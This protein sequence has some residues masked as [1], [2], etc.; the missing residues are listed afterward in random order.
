MNAARF[1]GGGLVGLVAV[2]VVAC[3]GSSGGGAQPPGKAPG[4]CAKPRGAYVV[5]TD[6][7]D[8]TC[9][10][11]PRHREEIM[12]LTEGGMGMQPGCTA[13][14]SH[15]TPSQNGCVY[16]LTQRCTHAGGLRS[17]ATASVQIPQVPTELRGT[18]VYQFE[19]GRE[20][21]LARYAVRYVKNGP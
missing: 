11:L 10:A 16:E 1:V 4:Q 17:L 19:E 7:I 14:D 12:V 6:M 5:T 18:V 20:R 8:G 13:V 15:W 9:N 3:G 2:V 21:C